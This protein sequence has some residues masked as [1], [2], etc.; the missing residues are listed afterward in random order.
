MN[1]VVEQ[2]DLPNILTITPATIVTELPVINIQAIPSE[3]ENMMFSYHSKIIVDGQM[4]SINTAGVIQLHEQK[5]EFEI[6]GRSSVGAEYPLK[7]L[8]VTFETPVNP[9]A[10]L[11][12]HPKKIRPGHHLDF[13]RTT[14][15]RSSGNDFGVTMIKDLAYSRFAV[16]NKLNFELMYGSPVQVFVNEMYYGL[17]NVRTESSLLGMAFLLDADTSLMGM[18]KVKDHSE[19]L[20]FDEG[21][22]LACEDL[23]T[24]IDTEDAAAI[25]DNVD[26]DNFIDYIIYQDYIGNADWANNI[27]AFNPGN[28]KFRFILYDVDLAGNAAIIPL[29]PKLEFI[30]ADIGKIY[31]AL[32]KNEG[33]DDRLNQRQ[34]ALYQ[35][36]SVQDFNT[37]VDELAATIENDI[38]Y[39]VAKYEMP[40]SSLHWKLEIEQLKLDFEGRDRSIRKKYDLE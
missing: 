15:L 23:L 5:I 19:N 31:R 6:R 28:G 13:L 4:T 10:S 30:S 35:S 37:I 20:K 24:A 2:E 17:M 12:L 25:W 3:F 21:N 26:I 38:P 9:L 14:R 1:L 34:K 8:G 16:E 39:L 18:L 11:G 27:K 7:S 36:F 40:E 22:R 29:L 32:Q 33:F